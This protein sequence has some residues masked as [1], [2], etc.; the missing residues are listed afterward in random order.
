MTMTPSA[1]MS[2]RPGPGLEPEL[3]S[4][5]RV[6]LPVWGV[7]AVWDAVCATA[8]GVFA[9]GGTA[10][11]IWRGV[12]STVLGPDALTAGTLALAAG[13]GLH[14]MVAFAWAAVFVGAVWVW[15]ALRR[16]ILTPGGALG[17]AVAYGPAIWLVMSLV[18]IP[19]ATGRPP[20]F[21]LRWWIQVAAHVPFVS[22]PLVY[23]ARRVLM[24]T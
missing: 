19:L 9:Y 15:P 10:A 11:G 3:P 13:L 18:V 22:L 24:R 4:F 1:G 20:R 5:T 7:T 2:L 14:A 6:L 16:T 23:T 12:A 21:N 17:V 8:L